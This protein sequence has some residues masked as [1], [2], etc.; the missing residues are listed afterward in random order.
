M[1][2]WPEWRDAEG[3]RGISEGSPLVEYYWKR[4]F[5]QV[6]QGLFDTWDYQVL[7]ACWNRNAFALLPSNNLTTNIGFG[8]DA[9][10]VWDRVPRYVLESEAKDLR[11]PL[12]HPENLAPSADKI[13]WKHIFGINYS[14]L[15]KSKAASIPFLGR[16]LRWLWRKFTRKNAE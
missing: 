5:D 7:F 11:F 12:T 10:R 4:I 15:M 9:T 6:H 16:K 13:I 1:Q 14:V 2:K 3:L 8:A